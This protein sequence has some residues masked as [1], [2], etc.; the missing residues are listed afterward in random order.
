MRVYIGHVVGMYGSKG[1]GPILGAHGFKLRQSRHVVVF[2][3]RRTPTN[4][5]KK[6]N[7]K[8]G[9]PKL[10][11]PRGLGIRGVRDLGIRDQGLSSELGV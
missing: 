5:D 11:N 3:S 6:L 10:P 4:M 7:P 9:S 8:H 1:L 2:M